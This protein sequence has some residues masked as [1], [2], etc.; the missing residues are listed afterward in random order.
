MKGV[1]E[2]YFEA[3]K[4]YH[5]GYVDLLGWQAALLLTGLGD[6]ELRICFGFWVYSFGRFFLAC[7]VLGVGFR[8]M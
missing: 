6:L 3:Y 2:L 5:I 7:R 4:Y 1:L 8:V